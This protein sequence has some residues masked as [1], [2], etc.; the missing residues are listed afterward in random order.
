M[1]KQ[2]FIFAYNPKVACTNW[3][4]ILRY[5]NGSE[6]Y[7][8]PSKAH[9]REQSGLTFLCDI[10]SLEYLLKN[11]NVPKYAFV[12][13][14]YDRILSAYLN[15]VEPYTNGQ[16]NSDQDNTY[17]YTVFL[18]IDKYRS[19]KLQ[20]K[21]CVDFYCFLHW[22]AHVDDFHTSNEHWK[23]QA[24]LLNIDKINF[25]FIG[26]FENITHDAPALLKKMNCDIDFPSQKDVKFAPTKA[27][28]KKAKYYSEEE[29]KLVNKIFLKDFLAFSY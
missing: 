15:K 3:K 11:D 9:D 4:C 26:K 23:P 8:D 2:N 14:P 6:D 17:F 20:G 19:E 21:P 29:E 22:L 5:L 24:D 16:R 10:E 18:E 7:L 25:D 28:E 27:S 1:E 12:R 13:N